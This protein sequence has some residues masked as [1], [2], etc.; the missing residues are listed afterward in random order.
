VICDPRVL[1]T[2]Q[3]KLSST[4]SRKIC[5]V[6]SNSVLAAATA[7]GEGGSM[8]PERLTSRRRVFRSVIIV[9]GVPFLLA[10]ILVIY[11]WR[12]PPVNREWVVET[13]EKHYQCDV[14]LKSFS[15]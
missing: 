14:E 2:C 1:G 9:L 12:F 13:L 5:Q 6:G 4:P 3:G 11:F 8:Q 10:A 15:A 7:T